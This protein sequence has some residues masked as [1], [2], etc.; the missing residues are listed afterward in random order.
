MA[1]SRVVP[2]LSDQH[3]RT[4]KVRSTSAAGASTDVLFRVEVRSVSHF[5]ASGRDHVFLKLYSK[6]PKRGKVRCPGTADEAN[7]GDE[8]TRAVAIAL[9]PE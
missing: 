6:H 1:D 8:M 2:S 5:M 9:V 4:G 3:G 7:R